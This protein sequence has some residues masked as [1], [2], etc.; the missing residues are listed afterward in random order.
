MNRRIRK[1]MLRGEAARYRYHHAAHE[2]RFNRR[3][4]MW[5]GRGTRLTPMA[6]GHAE[7]LYR[8]LDEALDREAATR[9]PSP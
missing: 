9:S 6:R 8:L 3:R 1:V 2:S 5:M 7:R 4:G